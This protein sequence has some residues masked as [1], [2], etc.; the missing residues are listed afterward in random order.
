MQYYTINNLFKKALT[1]FRRKY[2]QVYSIRELV[3][4]TNE[5]IDIDGPQKK[6]SRFG[7]LLSP[8]A[9][10]VGAIVLLALSYGL[11]WLQATNRH[12]TPKLTDHHATAVATF[13]VPPGPT[14]PL[15][16][17]LGDT[18]VS[19]SPAQL[20]HEFFNLETWGVSW[21]RIDVSWADIQPTSANQYNW[22]ALDRVVVAARAYHLQILGTVAYAPVWAEQK[23]CSADQ[24]CP[25]ARAS[26]FA[27]FAAAATSRYA[28]RG[29]HSWEIW[30]EPNLQGFWEP[31]P[32]P[33]AYTKLL[34]ATYSSIKHVDPK[35]TV[36]SGG[37][38]PLDFNPHSVHQQAF[39][40]GMYAAGAKPYFDALGYHPYSYPAPPSYVVSW[41]GW[42][43]MNDL[44]GSIRSIMTAY[45]DSQKPLWITEYGAP[46]NGAGAVA[47]VSN[48][49]FTAGPN[50]VSEDLQALMLTQSVAA[51]RATPWLQNFFWYSYQDLGTFPSTNENFFGLLRYNGAPKASVTALRQATASGQ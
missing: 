22:A 11:W 10:V 50:H 34:A 20:K 16:I 49:N 7:S 5:L 28:P 27:A 14:K 4:I 1:P 26:Q 17:A 45:G 30:N 33:T 25:P 35:A 36:I 23:P 42:S 24:K 39:L 43:S 6:R 41:S 31:A 15:G 19:L 21:I 44:P 2:H 29:L 3:T 47:T 37:L 32:D 46:T 9:L 51:Y 18:A 12:D 13:S 8:R 40:S 38:G 48:Y